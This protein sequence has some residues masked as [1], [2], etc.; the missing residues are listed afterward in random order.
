AIEGNTVGLRARNV[1]EGR[2]GGESIAVYRIAHDAV[3]VR[4]CQVELVA[5]GGER[6]SVREGDVV[7]DRRHLSA[8]GVPSAGA[9]AEVAGVVAA[10]VC[11][12]EGP[13]AIECTIVGGGAVG[14]VDRGDPAIRDELDPRDD[15]TR[16]TATEGR[17]L[18]H[19]ESAIGEAGDAVGA[20]SRLDAAFDRRIGGRVEHESDD[21]AS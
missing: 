9:G 14:D 6:D 10:G 15:G 17:V 12:P 8:R 4:V 21:L 3:S 11:V 16:R 5:G 7:C 20:A 19:G 2:G 13:V 18:Q 1:G